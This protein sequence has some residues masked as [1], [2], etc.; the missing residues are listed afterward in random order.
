M[1]QVTWPKFGHEL[2]EGLDTTKDGRSDRQWQRDKLVHGVDQLELRDEEEW[3]SRVQA[4]RND[5][6]RDTR[7]DGRDKTEREKR[8]F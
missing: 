3:W 6:F 2:Q 5:N 8:P 1:D 4:N 7:K